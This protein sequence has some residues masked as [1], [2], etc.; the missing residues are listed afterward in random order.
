MPPRF[1]FAIGFL[2]VSFVTQQSVTAAA[3][4]ADDSHKPPAEEVKDESG[5][6]FMEEIP[7]KN[8]PQASQPQPKLV[9]DLTRIDVPVDPNGNIVP[10]KNTETGPVLPFYSRME[11]SFQPLYQPV[12]VWGYP[13]G[14][15]PIYGINPYM[16]P[17]GYG[18]YGPGPSIGVGFGGGS[19]RFGMGGARAPYFPPPSP[20][21][22]PLASPWFVPPAMMPPVATP[23]PYVYSPA[24]S[25]F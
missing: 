12:P 11:Q 18:R 1:L 9:P 23:A 7:S 16:N 21:G 4:V 13:Y 19:F 3:A 25:Q 10:L 6:T 2:F 15:M 8:P 17:Y 5:N 20:F 22:F 24:Y 14:G